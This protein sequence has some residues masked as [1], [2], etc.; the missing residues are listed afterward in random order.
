VSG[1][2]HYVLNYHQ[3]HMRLRRS[4]SDSS[5]SWAY[6]QDGEEDAKKLTF[7]HVSWCVLVRSV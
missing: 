7:R 3:W 4:V 1:A 2:A 6:S 5:N